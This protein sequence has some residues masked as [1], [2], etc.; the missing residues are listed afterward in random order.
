MSVRYLT[1]EEIISIGRRIVDKNLNVRDFGLVA[2][3]RA[4]HS[5]HR[6]S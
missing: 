6:L 1:A 2:S 5:G 4:A 3:A